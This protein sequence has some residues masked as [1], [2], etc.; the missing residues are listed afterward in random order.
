MGEI[1]GF[2]SRRGAKDKDRDL[3]KVLAS[4]PVVMLQWIPQVIY[5]ESWSNVAGF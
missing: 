3:K 2:N 4:I 5:W 1:G